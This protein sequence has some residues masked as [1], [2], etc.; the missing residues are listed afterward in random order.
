MVCDRC[1]VDLGMDNELKIAR[2]TY[3]AISKYKE[4]ITSRG[5]IQEYWC[6]TKHLLHAEGHTEENIANASKE[7][8][9]ER[10][11]QLGVL[12]NIIR[13]L[14]QQIVKMALT[15]EYGRIQNKY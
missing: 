4:D 9:L 5:S 15:D 3:N 14:R 11:N 7:G 8:D 6:L 13:T 2:R 12:L 10:V 1:V